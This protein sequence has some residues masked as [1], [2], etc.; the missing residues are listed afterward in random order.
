MAED[1]RPVSKRRRPE[2]E[3]L[4]QNTIE[5]VQK[6]ARE[7]SMAARH[8]ASAANAGTAKASL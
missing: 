1:A 3:L 6:R 4:F 7:L 5:Y 2:L 8:S